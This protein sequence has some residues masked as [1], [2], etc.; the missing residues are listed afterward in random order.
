[1]SLVQGRARLPG[2]VGDGMPT[3][4]RRTLRGTVGSGER[5]N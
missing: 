3:G 4:A 2:R 1:M 5:D